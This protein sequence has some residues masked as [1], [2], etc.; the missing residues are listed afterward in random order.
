MEGGSEARGGVG[1]GSVRGEEGQRR[2][3]TALE[4]GRE[5]G[6][7]RS[8]QSE[9]SVGAHLENDVRPERRLRR[10]DDRRA[11]RRVLRVAELG[12]HAGVPLHRHREAALDERDDRRRDDRDAP[13]VC[14]RLARHAD[15]EVL[16]GHAARRGG[17]GG[18][19]GG[20]A[21]LGGARAPAQ[22]APQRPRGEAAGGAR[23]G[24]LHAEHDGDSAV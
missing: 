7:G 3:V 24:L 10:L 15:H 17:G 1:R 12:Q 9:P 16:V 19:G 14:E 4:R 13:L 6:V 21:L 20:G 2:L 18:G 5:G 22:A 8:H 23:R 11:G